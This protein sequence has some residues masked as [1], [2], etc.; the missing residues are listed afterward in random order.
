VA[1]HA[2]YRVTRC[3]MRHSMHDVMKGAAALKD[4]PG[5]GSLN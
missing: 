3:V 1:K 5:A 4:G 2:V